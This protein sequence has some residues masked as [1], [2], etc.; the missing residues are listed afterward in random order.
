MMQ[1]QALPIDRRVAAQMLDT[2]SQ[3]ITGSA[4]K[5]MD[6]IATFEQQ[7]GQVG[8]I[9]AGNA[10]DQCGLCLVFHG[11]PQESAFGPY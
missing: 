7:L 5:T 11:S 10:G 4:H 1:E 3:Q 8:A 2:R 9:L 6:S